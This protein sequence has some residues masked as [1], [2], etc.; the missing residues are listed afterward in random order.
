MFFP[1][2]VH[3]HLQPVLGGEIEKPF[4]RH[5]VN[6]QHIRAEFLDEFKI[7][8]CLLR[9]SEHLSAVIG[10]ERPVSDSLDIEFPAR[11]AKELPVHF[12]AIR[13]VDGSV[14]R[15]GI[16]TISLRLASEPSPSAVPT[17]A[18]AFFLRRSDIS[19]SGWRPDRMHSYLRAA[20]CVPDPRRGSFRSGSVIPA[21]AP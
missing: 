8:R 9:R 17:A 11:A 7:L 3:Q 18:P 4:W 1:R 6:A 19:G 15:A 13:T 14:H 5:V 20:R 12:D 10:R 16:L 2:D 21:R